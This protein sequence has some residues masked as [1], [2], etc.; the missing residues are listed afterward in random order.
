MPQVSASWRAE[1][2]PGLLRRVEQR[3]TEGPASQGEA[4]GRSRAG[5]EK[6]LPQGLW[7]SPER[8]ARGAGRECVRV[9]WERPAGRLGSAG[10]SSM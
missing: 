4:E 8:G 5:L 10:L 6:S 1:Q 7:G 9:Q 2:L 3:C